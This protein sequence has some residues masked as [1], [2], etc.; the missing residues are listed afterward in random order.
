M[1]IPTS[2]VVVLS[3]GRNHLPIFWVWILLFEQIFRPGPGNTYNN[4]GIDIFNTVLYKYNTQYRAPL[5][6]LPVEVLY[7]SL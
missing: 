1:H 4:I 3:V 5:L 2:R 7:Q 6:P